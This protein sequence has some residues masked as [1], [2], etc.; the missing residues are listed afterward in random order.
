MANEDEL[1]QA[2]KRHADQLVEAGSAPFPNDY[3]VTSAMEKLRKGLVAL[4]N[5]PE[6]DRADLPSETDLPDNAEVFHLW[7]R[8]MAKRGPFLVVRTPT[9]DA[10]TLVRKDLLPASEAEQLRNLDLADHVAV[11][12]PLIRTKTGA[13]A[14]RADSYRHLGKSLLPPPAK[15]H[16]LKDVEKRYRERY[17]D[18][19]VNPDVADIFRARTIIL[20]TLRGF[21]DEQGFL[22]VETPLLHMVRG[23]AT[24]KPFLTHHNALDLELF[25]RIAPELYLKRLLV[26]GFERVY[27]I[28][29]TFRN[30]GISTRHNPEFTLLEFYMAYA[31]HMMLMDITVDLFR[32]ADAAVR[33][34]F[35]KFS[36]ER[37]FDLAADWAR[38]T[39][40][41]A[42]AAQSRETNPEHVTAL[43]GLLDLQ[44]LRDP[45]TLQRVLE[46][47]FDAIDPQL[48][49]ALT[50]AQ[51]H[52]DRIF[53]LFEHLAEPALTR[54][55]RTPDGKH[56]VPV[57]IHEF[58]RSVSP[59]ARCND[60]DPEWV[61]RFELFVEG[62]ELVN[63]FS[64]LNDPED[65]AQRFRAQ[66]D[67]RSRGDE[68]AM[69]Y[70]A[71]YIRA[72]S[73]GM[74]PAAGFG[75]GLD[76]LV[77]ML[78]GSPS[79]RDVL[80]FPLM[81]PETAKADDVEGNGPAS[82]T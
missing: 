55:Y 72:L 75:L 45:E 23:G 25:M 76:R 56:S 12:G 61:D 80:L 65:Q 48:R 15:W 82:G 31:D 1:Y 29:R 79:I 7:G 16:G 30:E 13:A 49:K 21:L 22:E 73:H 62:Q 51:G 35:P 77:M 27:E 14:L 17:V 38:V 66:L 71:D 32:Q 4:A 33:T 26:G 43:S 46:P 24:A 36:E 10:Q 39:M 68:E 63:A 20:K 74:P 9:G 58:P 64:E 60:Q 41:E 67:N 81:R 59:L 70:D 18:L 5:G 54:L 11:S 19:F 52:G 78:T 34:Q 44:T 37:P 3:R 57:F 42:V 6:E 47:Q 50:Q 40:R 28:G 69:D 2:R 8:V 53:A